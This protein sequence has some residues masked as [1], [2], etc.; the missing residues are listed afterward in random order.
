MARLQQQVDEPLVPLYVNLE[1]QSPA[2][3]AAAGPTGTPL[4]VPIPRP[5]LDEGPH[6]SYALQWFSF[7]LLTVIVY[8]LLLRRV[9]RRRLQ[10]DPDDAPPAEPG[11]MGGAELAD[12]PLLPGSS[13]DLR[14]TRSSP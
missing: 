13:S 5:E 11:T 9:A 10:G 2:Q 14:P 12:G 8:P 1:T 6:L 4:P 7:A 3:S